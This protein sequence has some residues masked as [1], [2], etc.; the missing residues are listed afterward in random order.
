MEPTMTFEG[1]AYYLLVMIAVVAIVI[2]IQTRKEKQNG[3]NRT[4]FFKRIGVWNRFAN[5]RFATYAFLA[6]FGF[7]VGYWF[8]RISNIFR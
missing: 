7:C 2:Y 6:L 1:I 8:D 5:R 3:I 4:I